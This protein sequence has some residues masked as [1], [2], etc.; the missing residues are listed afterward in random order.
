M[1]IYFKYIPTKDYPMWAYD[2]PNLEQHVYKWIPSQ[3]FSSETQ[4]EEY[5]YDGRPIPYDED[6]DYPHLDDPRV[7]GWPINMNDPMWKDWY[8]RQTLRYTEPFE[9]F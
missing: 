9:L 1:K 5:L 2:L 4:L 7:G 3:V 6:F 8:E